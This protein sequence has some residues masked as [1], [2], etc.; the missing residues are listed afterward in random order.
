MSQAPVRV[1]IGSADRSIIEQRV[2]Q[3]SVQKRT[4]APV[5]F[6]ILNGTHGEVRGPRGEPVPNPLGDRLRRMSTA[7]PFTFFRY[8]IPELCGFA[9][10]AIYCDADQLVMDDIE[11]LWS[12]PLG[13]AGAAMCPAYRRGRWATSVMVLDCAKFRLDLPAVLGD[14]ERGELS[15]VDLNYFT[16]RFLARYPLKIT[17]LAPVWNSL[18]C[19]G[20]DVKLLHFTNLNMQPWRFT[21]HPAEE[22]WAE[23][24]QAAY[25]DGYLNRQMIRDAIDKE[26]YRPDL[27]DMA[28]KGVRLGLWE[29]LKRRLG[30][31]VM[32]AKFMTPRQYLYN[33]HI[34]IQR[35]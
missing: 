8:A 4:R 29:R 27:L 24:L 21:M 15:L 10:R 31:V 13:D 32:N 28:E 17:P 22:L 34:G 19:P 26:G 6:Y 2:L 30:A 16:D 35:I 14:V 20:R 25:R 23:H 3:W 11:E 18:D 1:F 5:E 33:L 12:T 9:G 7:T